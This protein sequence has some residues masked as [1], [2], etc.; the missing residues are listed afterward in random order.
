[1]SA[2]IYIYI[3]LSL[4]IYIYIYRVRYIYIYI[5]LSIYIYIYI[6]PCE[7]HS[8][9]LY[10]ATVRVPLSSGGCLRL[11]PP[12]PRSHNVSIIYTLQ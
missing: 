1:M 2:H 10:T 4:Y 6:S 5:S 11:S 3:S 7:A 12:L 9:E 8:A